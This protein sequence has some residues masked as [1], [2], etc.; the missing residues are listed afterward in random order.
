MNSEKSLQRMKQFIK[1]RFRELRLGDITDPRCRQGKRYHLPDLL[2]LIILGLM[3]GKK[4]LGQ[5]ESFVAWMP[6][7]LRQELK[8]PHRGADTTLREL[9]C[10]NSF[11]KSLRPLLHRVIHKA[12]RRKALP[13]QQLPFH[14]IAM[15]GKA[16]AFNHWDKNYVQKQ[17][18]ERKLKRPP[19]GLL[20]TTTMTLV[21]AQGKPCVDVSP[22]PACTNETGHFPMA[23]GELI[24]TY[25]DLFRLVSYD[26]GAGH[27]KNGRCV[28]N[29]GKDYLFRL[30]DPRWNMYQ[31]AFELCQQKEPM[32]ESTSV[33]SNHE[34]VRRSLRLVSIHC[35]KL[36]RLARKGFFWEHAHTLILIETQKFRNGVCVSEESE[37][38]LY[39]SSLTA[40]ALTKEQWLFATVGHWAVETTHQILDYVFEEDE[41]PW[42]ESD[43]N[44]TLALVV[45]RRVAYTLLTLFRSVTQRS[46]QNRQRP[47][48]DIVEWVT[49]ALLRVTQNDRPNLRVAALR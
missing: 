13:I 18:A 19:Y 47:W 2:R 16:T 15:D 45:L 24:R 49:V 42:I 31:S 21:T 40:D 6:K 33:I 22:I 29:A 5:L 1:K 37:H 48:R 14:M 17:D 26:A 10:R 39:I 38:K 43:A 41:H 30:N 46:D 25:G 8:L 27:E 3:S 34:E 44:G 4:S 20:R 36:P 32:F 11:W 12:Q 9:L 23:F 7:Q 28:V 35:G